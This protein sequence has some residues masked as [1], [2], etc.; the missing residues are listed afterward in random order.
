GGRDPIGKFEA[1]MDGVGDDAR[2]KF[3]RD[4]MADLLGAGV[5]A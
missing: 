3:Y 4:N 2:R 1:T 5:S